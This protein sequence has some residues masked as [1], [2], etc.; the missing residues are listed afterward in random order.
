[1]CVRAEMYSC[2]DACVCTSVRVCVCP[3]LCVCVC[4]C[5]SVR[6]SVRACVRACLCVCAC[7]CVVDICTYLF[8][9]LLTAVVCS[10]LLCTYALSISI[11]LSSII[12]LLLLHG[13]L[14]TF[15]LCDCNFDTGVA[16]FLDARRPQ[17]TVRRWEFH[18]NYT[19]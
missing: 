1:M 9:R 4:V 2:S 16:C 14:L 3:C 19:V 13:I 5:T 15:A 17:G 8:T 7:A 6:T 18:W 10:L 11:P 12:T